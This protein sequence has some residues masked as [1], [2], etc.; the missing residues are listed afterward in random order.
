MG[1]ELQDLYFFYYLPINTINLTNR[2]DNKIPITIPT[3]MPVIID[4]FFFAHYSTF[5]E[6][7][8]CLHIDML[9]QASVYIIM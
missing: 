6:F 2:K 8:E 1:A 7:P 9:T 3:P 5:E 4:L